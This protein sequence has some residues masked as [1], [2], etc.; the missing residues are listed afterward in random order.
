MISYRWARQ[1]HLVLVWVLKMVLTR[2]L[3]SLLGMQ[4]NLIL[5]STTKS[6]QL[7]SARITNVLDESKTIMNK[8]SVYLS[9]GVFQLPYAFFNKPDFISLCSALL[10]FYIWPYSSVITRLIQKQEFKVKAYGCLF[11]ITLWF[12]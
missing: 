2:H 5:L 6:V 9:F 10:L 4:N 1:W 3:N 12:D 11:L 7:Y 8:V